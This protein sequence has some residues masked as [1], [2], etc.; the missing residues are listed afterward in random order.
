METDLSLFDKGS[1]TAGPKLKVL[2]WYV[3]NYTIFN[4]AIPWPS[5]LK[6]KILRLF[7]ATIGSGLNIKP[8]VRIKNP[9][10]L[11][12]GNN[13]WIGES[14]WID[15]LENVTI[16]NNV[17]LSQGAMLLTGNHDFTVSSF[18]YRLG[19][20]EIQD[21]VW[22]GAK[23]VVC[24]GVTC[25]SHSILTVNSVATK[26]LSAWH[27]YGGSPSTFIKIRKISA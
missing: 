11:V 9:W 23:S 1:Y 8:K 3:V 18:P 20:I 2:I 14:V 26:N 10:R 6:T 12:V 7:G 13:C 22:I 16:G 21:G 24:P 27:I 5:S 25:E 17:C 4:S 19:K 15:N